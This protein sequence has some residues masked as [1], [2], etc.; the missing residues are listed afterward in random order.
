[1]ANRR[2]TVREQS[3]SILRP[4]K[5]RFL[6]KTF[7]QFTTP[8]LSTSAY[9]AEQPYMAVDSQQQLRGQRQGTQYA[10]MAKPQSSALL[11]YQL[12]L[13]RRREQPSLHDRALFIFEATPVGRIYE[14]IDA[15]LSIAFCV[16]Y[17]WNTKYARVNDR[18]QALPLW[19]K[20]IERLLALVLLIM[21][22]PRYYLYHRPLA[23]LFKPFSLATWLSTVSVL[24]AWII[25]DTTIGPDIDLTYM[26]AGGMIFFYPARFIRV[27]FAIQE[28]LRPVKMVYVQLS[29]ISRQ[30][31]MVG[32]TVL[33]AILTISAVLHIV[34][35]KLATYQNQNPPSTTFFD[36]FF[37]TTV[38]TVTG[39]RSTDVPDTR[40]TRVVNLFVIA[41]GFL[42]LPKK[43]T[44]LISLINSQNHYDYKLPEPTDTEETYVVIS[45][46]SEV[47]EEHIAGFLHEF[48]HVDHGVMQSINLRATVLRPVEPGQVLKQVLGD[49]SL[50]SRVSYIT[51]TVT[52]FTSLNNIQCGHAK[53]AFLLAS[54]NSGEDL[55]EA[56]AK[57]MMRALSLRKFNSDIK[58]FVEVHLRESVQNFDYLAEFVICKQDLIDGLISQS[59]LVPGLAS[60]LIIL[61]TSVS[62][63]TIADLT[64]TAK[65]RDM[66]WMQT[67]LNS[68]SQEF[69]TSNL[70]ASFAGMRFIEVVEIVYRHIGVLIIGY[71]T[72]SD[73]KIRRSTVKISVDPAHVMHANEICVVTASDVYDA[74]R[75]STFDASQ[76]AGR[77][78]YSDFNVGSS[79][80]TP[81]DL[82]ADTD[83]KSR[84]TSFSSRGI[85]LDDIAEPQEFEGRGRQ[86]LEITSGGDDDGM[87]LQP[88]VIP[89][90]LVRSQ[91]PAPSLSHA[92]GKDGV[93]LEFEDHFLICDCT[94]A[95]TRQFRTLISSIR[96]SPDSSIKNRTIVIITKKPPVTN[97][98]GARIIKADK[99]KNVYYVAGSPTDRDDLERAGVV[100]AARCLILSDAKQSEK[101]YVTTQTADA[102]ALQ[103]GLNF[104][105]MNQRDRMIVIECLH[106]D[107]IKLIGQTR[108]IDSDDDHV[109]QY[110]RPSFMGGSVVCPALADALT[111]QCFYNP[112]MLQICSAFL[113]TGDG[114]S[115]V[116]LV[117]V[118][119]E[120][121][122]QPYGA[123]V[124]IVLKGGSDA[125]LGIP[126]GLR[127][128]RAVA[129]GPKLWYPAINPAQDLELKSGDSVYVLKH[130]S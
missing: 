78:Y 98:D 84:T 70:H 64:A 107:T 101:T 100:N 49:P 96:N 14:L 42:W 120:M 103:T 30:A 116:S 15:G 63:S 108:T 75:I 44:H 104:E 72:D 87:T 51:G 28:T 29:P 59:I 13:D 73:V 67:Y 88:L 121:Y 16:L 115:H 41:A 26:S 89:V 77:Q 99:F 113:F 97:R 80:F 33:C 9:G 48:L 122:G 83:Q 109:K 40:F 27:N 127:R 20:V 85:E 119:A 1:M 4:W 7:Q 32:S 112:F 105:A 53:A 57:Q 47:S 6:P 111:S 93:D 66:Q 56:D 124:S 128:S 54:R 38:G 102:R 117:Q 36:S 86:N 74:D 61:S 125:G 43:L 58:I 19:S 31:S 24:I 68:L 8:S 126:L 106:Q 10:A 46:E 52:S 45:G 18:Y 92:A 37:L 71:G 79:V 50:A 65:K 62:D 17:I 35:Y 5:Q 12:D 39:M 81:A 69:Y 34:A 114:A 55:T 60:M 11:Q 129:M 22:F 3:S 21:Y 2:Q 25:D 118:P 23:F 110:L 95:T 123:L 94:D 90:P 91:S 82:S 76:V 130:L